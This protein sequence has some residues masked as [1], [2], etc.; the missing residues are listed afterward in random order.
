MNI[1]Y[2]ASLILPAKATTSFHI[3][4]IAERKGLWI[5]KGLIFRLIA[6]RSP[7]KM[8]GAGFAI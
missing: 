3:L 7:A 2:N 4:I 8:R 1:E 6:K 5:T